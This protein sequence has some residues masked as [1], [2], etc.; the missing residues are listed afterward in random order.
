MNTLT[1]IV[2]PAFIG[3]IAG[4]GHGFVSHHANLPLSLSD[5]IMQPLQSS[6][7]YRE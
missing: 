1:S 7:A 3:L 6:D 5:Q 2:L 4:V